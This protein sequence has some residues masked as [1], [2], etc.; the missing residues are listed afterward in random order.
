LPNP[1]PF[2][3]KSEIIISFFFLLGLGLA[4]L[5][6][7]PGL[8]GSLILDDFTNLSPLQQIS[9]V[10]NLPEVL[11]YLGI[12]TSSNLGRP[13]SLLSF[14]LQHNEFPVA[15][16]FKY[17]NVMIH[18]LNSCLLFVF[19]LLVGKLSGLLGHRY[20]IIA[21]LTTILWLIHPLNVSTV[22]YV[23][24]RMTELSAF[25]TL[26][27]LISYCIGRQ[28]FTQG[29][30][31]TGYLWVSCGVVLG[32]LLATLSKEN[33]VLLPLY[34]L[35]LEFV[36]FSRI[37]KPSYWKA[38]ITIFL[39][40]PL[41][42]FTAYIALNFNILV[43]NTYR[44][45]DFTL[46]ERLMSEAR[47]L[48][49][50]LYKTIITLPHSFGIFHDNYA[51][52]HGVLDP[53]QTGVAILFIAAL[54][55]TALYFKK[56]FPVYSFAILW[57]FA[58]HML[59]STFLPLELYFEHRNYL[60]VTGI[61]FAMVVYGF[62]LYD[63]LS[64]RTIKVAVAGA[65]VLY[66]SFIAAV[67]YSENELWG[68]VYKQAY[69]WSHENKNSLRAQLRLGGLL[70]A[71]EHYA[72]AADV[73]SEINQR[74]P[75]DTIASIEWLALSCHDKTVTR[76]NYEEMVLRLSRANIQVGIMSSL[77]GIVS[78]KEKHKCEA[79]P[80]ELLVHVLQ[81]LTEN[82]T[83]KTK[84]YFLYFILGRLYASERLL[85]PA[86]SN[87]D[88]AFALL[89][90]PQI[91]LLQT[92]WLTT[93]GLYKDARIYLEKARQSAKN[94]LLLDLALKKQFQLWD[95]A[96]TLLESKHSNPQ[97]QNNS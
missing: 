62:K 6:Y 34:L 17:I 57:F 29:K 39:A 86:M 56:R 36:L 31:I 89:K 48:A 67:T 41:V 77:D 1:L 52:S 12:S 58:G 65:G 83:F 44:T 33:G 15:W 37:A 82:P 18:L 27:G 10:T 75:N 64:T 32:G 91:P 81:A 74:F 59:E 2:F 24:Q 3:N 19:L 38:W 87:L 23:I 90:T 93:A 85:D 92:E 25:F 49:D 14:A 45:R 40:G 50:Y 79:V 20:K 30:T 16:W 60:P 53:P 9:D 22:Q 8:T 35:V 69:A 68:D 54:I 71:T 4:L 42:V 46:L 72:K 5:I 97:Q 80:D 70:T 51:V 11:F 84:R 28:Y 95:E 96:I 66:I 21:L 55:A 26:A 94:K 61:L 47:V 88:K 63:T 13:I 7:W 73:Y 76:P 78:L 43:L